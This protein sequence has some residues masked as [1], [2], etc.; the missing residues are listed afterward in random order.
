LGAAL[1]MNLKANHPNFKIWGGAQSDID[2]VTAI[3]RERLQASGGPFLFG[4]RTAADAMYAP[5]CARFATYH[6]PLDPVCSA[7]RDTI[8][9]MPEM[10]EW[11]AAALS[12]PEQVEELEMEF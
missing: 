7:Y 9:A 2:R 6:V 12:E 5:V 1:P 11:T 10:I 8:L 4:A 3:W